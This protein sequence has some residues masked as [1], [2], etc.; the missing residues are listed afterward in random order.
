M[1]NSINGSRI[2]TF[3]ISAEGAQG[4][5]G[6]APPPHS[7][8]RF[9]FGGKNLFNSLPRNNILFFKIVLGK[10]DSVAKNGTRA[11]PKQKR[12]PLPFLLS[13]SFFYEVGQGAQWGSV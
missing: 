12:R 7:H 2:G 3:C 4:G 5:T 8:P 1:E 10:T 13:L 9:C 6:R 11:S